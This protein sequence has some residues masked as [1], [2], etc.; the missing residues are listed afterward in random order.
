MTGTDGLDGWMY[1]LYSTKALGRSFLFMCIS[2]GKTMIGWMSFGF[3]F[4]GTG[5][6]LYDF[7]SV[8]GTFG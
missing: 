4:E 6:A 1:E 5:G 2:L 7:T 8:I 3:M